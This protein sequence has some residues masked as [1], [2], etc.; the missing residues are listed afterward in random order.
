M[1]QFG[2][3][4][5]ISTRTRTQV[6]MAVKSSLLFGMGRPSSELQLAVGEVEPAG[7]GLFYVDIEMSIPMASS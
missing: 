7:D 6:A 5:V 4:R 3:A 1:S 2:L